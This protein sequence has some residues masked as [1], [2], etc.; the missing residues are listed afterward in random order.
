[1]VEA[2]AQEHKLIEGSS[3]VPRA[4]EQVHDSKV[5]LL[6]AG[7]TAAGT[8]VG[9]AE[10]TQRAPSRA[11]EYQQFTIDEAF[12]SAEVPEKSEEFLVNIRVNVLGNS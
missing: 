2:N 1:M 11:A 8:Q 9:N 7:R 12:R 4:A 3:G 10:Y 6:N 5:R